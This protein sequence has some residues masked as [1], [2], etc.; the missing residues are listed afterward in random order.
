[1]VVKVGESRL[2]PEQCDFIQKI[3]SKEMVFCFILIHM[4]RQPGAKAI[5]LY[6]GK[7]LLILRDDIPSIIFPNTWSPPGGG[8]EEGETPEQAMKRELLEEISIIPQSI[9]LLST[10]VY[11]D[12]SI[13]YRFFAYLS[14][15]EYTKIALG[16][17]GQR[18]DWF[19][20][21]EA[22]NI[23]LSPNFRIFLEKEEESLR[24]IMG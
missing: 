15:E 2:P 7:M 13:V 21:E 9:H 20:Y 24:K 19:T 17:E 4:P 5:I 23:N 16:E 6:Q 8:I 1:M 22:L 12:S 10:M 11:E 14:A 18:M 3:I